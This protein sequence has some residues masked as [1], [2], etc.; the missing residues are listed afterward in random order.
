MSSTKPVFKSHLERL[1]EALNDAF[2]KIN[3]EEI[4]LRRQLAIALA[5]PRNTKIVTK[6]DQ[7]KILE[8]LQKLAADDIEKH[9]GD[10]KAFRDFMDKYAAGTLDL[11]TS[12]KILKEIKPINI[13]MKK[14]Y[15]AYIV[16]SRAI[17][18]IQ[19]IADTLNKHIKGKITEQAI[20][21]YVSQFEALVKKINDNPIIVTSLPKKMRKINL[22]NFNFVNQCKE[23]IRNFGALG[24]TNKQ[25]II[26]AFS[27]LKSEPEKKQASEKPEDQEVEQTEQKVKQEEQEV[28]QQPDNITQTSRIEELTARIE[29]LE[30]QLERA[31]LDFVSYDKVQQDKMNELERRNRQL[32]QQITDLKSNA[33]DS[34]QTKL[35]EMENENKRLEEER[36]KA[37]DEKRASAQEYERELQDR[38]NKIDELTK[39]IYVLKSQ[40]IQIRQDITRDKKNFSS[41]EHEVQQK[42]RD[43]KKLES[44]LNDQRKK[45]DRLEELAQAKVRQQIEMGQEYDAAGAAYKDAK[46]M[47]EQIEGI[48]EELQKERDKLAAERKEF[49][50]SKNTTMADARTELSD[51]KSKLDAKEAVLN[52][53]EKEILALED[54][55]KKR[56]IP[57]IGLDSLQED[58]NK[59]KENI[60]RLQNII[61]LQKK[62]ANLIRTNELPALAKAV[63]VSIADNNKLKEQILNL[64]R[65]NQNLQKEAEQEMSK[66]QL[67]MDALTRNNDRLEEMVQDNESIVS[68][69]K[70]K[71]SDA[72]KQL[73]FAQKKSEQVKRSSVS[74]QAEVSN[75]QVRYSGLMGEIVEA[76]ER[77]EELSKVEERAAAEIKEA[78]NDFKTL[79]DEMQATMDADLEAAGKDRETQSGLIQQLTEKNSQLELDLAEVRENNVVELK[80]AQEK[81]K[82]LNQ[83]LSELRPQV[84]SLQHQLAKQEAINADQISKIDDL[85]RGNLELEAQ[86]ETISTEKD[87]ANSKLAASEQLRKE[88]DVKHAAE[89]VALIS[90]RDFFKGQ[91]KIVQG[92]LDI[93]QGQL[94][95]KESELQTEY[96]RNRELVDKN[97]DL[98]SKLTQKPATATKVPESETSQP[99]GEVQGGMIAKMKTGSEP[100][101]HYETKTASDLK[102]TE[103][104]SKTDSDKLTFATAHKEELKKDFFLLRALKVGKKSKEKRTITDFILT[105]PGMENLGKKIKET[106]EKKAK[107]VSDA[108]QETL[109]NEYKAWQKEKGVTKEKTLG[110]DKKEGFEKWKEKRDVKKR[111]FKE[112]QVIND[113]ESSSFVVKVNNVEKIRVRPENDK[114][115]IELRMLSASPSDQE[116]TIFFETAR[117]IARRTD[118][119]NIKFDSVPN[120]KKERMFEIGTTMGLNV[121][122]GSELKKAE[123]TKRRVERDPNEPEGGEGGSSLTARNRSKKQ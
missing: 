121:Q 102:T 52:D 96:K 48:R 33:E 69:L 6:Q 10:P 37:V 115:E 58:N 36:K 19:E 9:R 94:R 81:N 93:V 73:I 67:K 113:T 35:E 85:N 117:E 47:G 50:Q 12:G 56:N 64:E 92:Q 38:N 99:K 118:D 107:I 83:Q 114:N 27:K 100:K 106:F 72:E 3:N 59:L 98:Q 2:I 45:L 84:E 22:V 21:N 30:S 55:L 78:T 91:L 65:G 14:K 90:N 70:S 112:V 40:L 53:R 97:E 5:G 39:E 66:L 46:R 31:G 71:L 79:T 62:E 25:K 86:L 74:G 54:S 18:E 116:I 29:V 28:D 60:Q 23:D 111:V 61:E 77:I 44:Q 20:G 7:E 42:E 41:H 119:W 123:E 95:D 122:I 57:S 105:Q 75:M 120:D 51:R 34:S 89:R 80:A 24:E 88:L 82:A 110:I 68:D 32:N 4:N 103:E 87:E 63:E 26:D 43:L 16:A 13:E 104:E 15:E 101:P 11:I 108:P 1:A 17:K 109:E 49:E 8:R 76:N